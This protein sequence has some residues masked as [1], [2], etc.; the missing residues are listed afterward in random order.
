[1]DLPWRVL[2]RNPLYIL[3]PRPASRELARRDTRPKIDCRKR[4]EI[5]SGAR[6]F[7]WRIVAHHALCTLY[8]D[9]RSPFRSLWRGRFALRSLAEQG[10]SCAKEWW[11]T[12]KKVMHECGVLWYWHAM[13]PPVFSALTAFTHHADLAPKP[14]RRAFWSKRLVRSTCSCLMCRQQI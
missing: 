8:A 7:S 1:M 5:S 9:V 10:E 11:S 6:P 2:G 3:F 13:S 14:L 4:E 12:S